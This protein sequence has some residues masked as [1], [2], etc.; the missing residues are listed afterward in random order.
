MDKIKEMTEFGFAAKRIATILKMSEI[1]VRQLIKINNW[2]MQKEIFSKDKIIYI[3]D[4]YKQGVSAK[5]LGKKFSIDKRRVQKWADE[6]G[7]L[8]SK[9]EAGRFTFYDENYF[10]V[11]DTPDKAYW[12]GFFYADAYN[13]DKTCTF[14]LSLQAKDKSHL[15]KLAIVMKYP[16]DK[17][18]DGYS[19]L[20]DKIYPTATMK[21]Y[22]K[23][24]CTKMIELGCPRAKSFIIKYPN[25]LDS[26]LNNHFIRGMFDGDGSIKVSKK[27]NEWKWN[28]V[29]TKEC[30]QS[31]QDIFLFAVNFTIQYDC[32]SETNNNTYILYQGGNQKI[33]TMLNWIYKDSAI[34]N[35]LDRKYDRYLKLINQ[36]NSRTI[37]RDDH[38]VTKHH[39]EEILQLSNSISATEIA[40]KFEVNPVTIK[41]F[42]K[43]NA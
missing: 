40:D 42:L 23:H 9:K 20:N 1:E 22:S 30:C 17:I 28:L 38:F 27:F 36:Q 29:S 31:I 7:V 12:L 21:L 16:V 25:W 18:I 6:N 37:K 13:S 43:A 14:S 35:R 34:E 41:R 10:D 39:K 3:C 4:L 2:V 8:R 11:I 24:L 32:I 26:K 5:A 19:E 33:L 15:E